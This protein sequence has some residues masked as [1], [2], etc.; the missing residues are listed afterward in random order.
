MEV[1]GQFHTLATLPPEQRAPVTLLAGLG[2][3]AGLDSLQ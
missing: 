2:S 1:D 3:R